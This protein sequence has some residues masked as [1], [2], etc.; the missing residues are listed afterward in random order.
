MTP[1]VRA[2]MAALEAWVV[3]GTPAPTAPRV[4][5]SGVEVV[6]DENGNAVGGIRT[7]AVDAPVSSLTGAGNPS[8]VF[9]TLFGQEAPFD[10]AKLVALYGDNATYV[11]KVT[12]SADDAVKKGFLLQAERDEIVAEAKASGVP[13]G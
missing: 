2:A 7:P 12:A 8:S 13:T 6:R 4:E 11:A 9:C 10:Q 1:V 3:E 5:G